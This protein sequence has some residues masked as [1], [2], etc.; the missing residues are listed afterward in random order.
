MKQR[1]LTGLVLATVTL[2]PVAY[3]GILPI[4]ILAVVLAWLGHRE[5]SG[6][7]TGEKRSVPIVGT[8]LLV[9][10][11]L[12]FWLN[13]GLLEK[14]V[15]P[16]GWALTWAVFIGLTPLVYHLRDWPKP[17]VLQA[18]FASTVWLTIPLLSLIWLHQLPDQTGLW[19]LANPMLLSIVPVWAGDTAAIVIGKKFGRH[20]MALQISPG[21]TW[22]GSIANFIAATLVGWGLGPLVG[23]SPMMGL[24]CGMLCGVLGQLGD[25]FESYVKRQAGVKDSGDLLPGHGGIMDRLDSVLFAAPVIAVAISRLA[26][27]I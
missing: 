20:P 23:Q 11:S 22:E 18:E 25:L 24:L 12:F 5:I 19:N 8:A 3:V 13:R 26:G 6:L 4:C 2:L 27:K 14:L 17:L 9:T 21:K 15:Q 7:L 1:V 10:A 16:E